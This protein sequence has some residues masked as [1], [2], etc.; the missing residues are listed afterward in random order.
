MEKWLRTTDLKCHLL[1]LHQY[2]GLKGQIYIDLIIM[3]ANTRDEIFSCV[4][5]AVS[6][7]FLS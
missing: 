5:V 4:K 1:I 6:I 2:S 7:K 3:I